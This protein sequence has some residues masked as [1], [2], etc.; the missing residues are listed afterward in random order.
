VALL[1]QAHYAPAVGARPL[2][3]WA[4]TANNNEKLAFLAK[5]CLLLIDDF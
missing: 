5:D 4:S 3:N 1:A 2:T